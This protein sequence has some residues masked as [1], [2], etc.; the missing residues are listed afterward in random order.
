M[1]GMA[2]DD[3][4]EW[5][6]RGAGHDDDG[7]VLRRGEIEESGDKVRSDEERLEHMEIRMRERGEERIK[8]GYWSTW[9]W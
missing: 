9:R 5:T 4:L 8:W 3:K 7:K 1:T 2:R 6:H